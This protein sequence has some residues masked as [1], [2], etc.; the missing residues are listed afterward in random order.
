[1]IVVQVNK[2][3]HLSAVM[4]CHRH[5]TRNAWRSGQEVRFAVN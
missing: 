4:R 2:I 1:M 3:W 5:D